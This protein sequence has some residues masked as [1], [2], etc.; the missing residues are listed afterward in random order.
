VALYHLSALAWREKGKF[1]VQDQALLWAA[2]SR[3][4][5]HL[6]ENFEAL[7]DTLADQDA[8]PLAR[9]LT[10]PEQAVHP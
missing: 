9:A 10:Q 2:F 8:W 6:D 7:V 5:E 3:E 4:V 1:S